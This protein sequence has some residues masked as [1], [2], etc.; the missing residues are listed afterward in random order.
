[1]FLLDHLVYSAL[2]VVADDSVYELALT[3]P[4]QIHRYPSFVVLLLVSSRPSSDTYCEENCHMV[5]MMLLLSQIVAKMMLRSLPVAI[6]ALCVA[7]EDSVC[8]ISL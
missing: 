4:P 6:S 1:M 2:C 5:S 3:K 8:E 7:A